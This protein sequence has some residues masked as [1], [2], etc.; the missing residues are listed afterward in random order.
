MPKSK[1]DKVK[2][3]EMQAKVD[4][5][6]NAMPQGDDEAYLLE[7]NPL[8]DAFEAK[9][10]KAIKAYEQAVKCDPDV[11]Y[12]GLWLLYMQALYQ[13]GYYD[14]LITVYDK[15]AAS[16]NWD[17]RCGPCYVP[18]TTTVGKF[19]RRDASI[20]DSRYDVSLLAMVALVYQSQFARAQDVEDSLVGYP[21]RAVQFHPHGGQSDFA[22]SSARTPH[23]AYV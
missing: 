5:A 13:A 20:A 4:K 21:S 22:I 15:L 14:D 11:D 2:D 16:A 18:C 23:G 17:A 8:V 19:V 12:P 3:R 7:A 6:A 9:M 1:A 10:R